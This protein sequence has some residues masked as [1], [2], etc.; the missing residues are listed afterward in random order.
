MPG[1]ITTPHVAGSNRRVRREMADVV[2]DDLERFLR[3]R[4]VQNRVTAQMLDRMT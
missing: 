4:A 3:G 1:A 2:L